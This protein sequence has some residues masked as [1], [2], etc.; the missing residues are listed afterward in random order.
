MARSSNAGPEAEDKMETDHSLYNKIET[1]LQK[2]VLEGYICCDKAI[3]DAE[4]KKIHQRYRVDLKA[5]ESF[6]RNTCVTY[7]KRT[8]PSVRRRLPQLVEK[9]VNGQISLQLLSREVNY[10]PFL[11]TRMLLEVLTICNTP[12][13]LRTILLDPSQILDDRT[14]LR[15]E[16]RL[17]FVDNDKP[18]S[19]IVQEIRDILVM[20]PMYGPESDLK[21]FLVG[22]EYE[23]LLMSELDKLGEL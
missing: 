14:L 11:L 13:Q 16:F 9:F 6:A 19:D 10:P 23:V 20:D 1:L 18:I 2:L 17:L 12:K 22:V 5:I 7:V 21:R 4:M 3:F 8:T 15:P